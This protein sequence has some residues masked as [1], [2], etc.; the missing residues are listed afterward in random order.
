MPATPASRAQLPVL[1]CTLALGLLTSACQAQ[2]APA[3]GTTA[4]P[5]L[6]TTRPL[7][8][9]DASN[10][11]DLL[12]GPRLREQAA[13]V[14]LDYAERGTPE[15]KAN[16]MEGLI[17]MPARLE[18]VVRANLRSANTGVRTVAA[19][20]AGKARLARLNDS[21][22]PLLDDS[23]PQVRA[24]AIFALMRN[25]ASVDPS[26]LGAMLD[27]PDTRV[28]SH[29]AFILGELR[30]KTAV[31]M[32]LEA[33]GAPAMRTDPQLDRLMRLQIA[34]A[35][36]KLGRE[37]AIHEVRAALYPARPED[38]EACALAVQILG[39]VKDQQVKSQLQMLSSERYDN[40]NPMPIEVRLAAAASLARMQENGPAA[41]AQGLLGA[42]SAP[43][44]A[45]AALVLGETGQKDWLP[46]LAPLLSDQVPLVR[47]AAAAAILKITE[48]T[49][50]GRQ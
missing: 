14:L 17:S 43:Q 48:N 4:T 10:P 24:A 39:Q 35:L 47:I 21:V 30:N 3:G 8:P 28:R 49:G 2:T 13:G 46:S 6:R 33:S 12:T 27:D 45:Q 40:G 19:M 44:R 32:L 25:G 41:M 5:G 36:V 29:A 42:E 23:T 34:E 50:Q 20:A 31:P 22:R 18:P 1:T 26:L 15:E 37:D 9:V 38:L 16:A 11:A 7:A